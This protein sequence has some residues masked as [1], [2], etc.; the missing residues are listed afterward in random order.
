MPQACKMLFVLYIASLSQAAR[1][2]PKLNSASSVSNVMDQIGSLLQVRGADAQVLARLGALASQQVTPGALESQNEILR[3]V[4]TEIEEEVEKKIKEGHLGTQRTI[5]EKINGLRETTSH[6]VNIKRDLADY[7]D[8]EW[9]SCVQAEKAKRVAIEEAED[10]LTQSRSRVGEPCQL[11]EDRAPFGWS[12]D[13]SKL[14]FACDISE[15]GNCESEV[16]KFNSQM[17]S[18]LA[19]LQ[20]DMAAKTQSWAEAKAQCDAA[21]ADVVEKQSARDSAVADWKH[22]REDCLHKHE[23]RQVSMCLFGAKLQVKC[24]KAAAYRTL[25]SEVD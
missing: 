5:N 19:D 1:V 9:N 17:D 3:K 6:V 23:S 12:A 21:K 25:L 11:Q 22:Q 7:A 8:T 16:S 4:I 10:A 18:M 2:N 14:Q 20:S 15:L 13:A 24:Q